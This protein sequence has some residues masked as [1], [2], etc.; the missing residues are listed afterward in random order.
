MRAWGGRSGA[1]TVPQDSRM[2]ELLR[3]KRVG[4]SPPSA[5]PWLSTPRTV[6]LDYAEGGGGGLSASTGRATH[7]PGTSR[8]RGGS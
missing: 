2:R 8:A 1:I 5:H 3:W 7:V 4:D 6:D